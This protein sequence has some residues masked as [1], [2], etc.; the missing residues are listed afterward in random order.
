MSMDEIIRTWKADEE[1]IELH[2][3]ASPVGRELDEHE[4][5]EVVGGV[6]DCTVITC[7]SVYSAIGNGPGILI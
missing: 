4:L 6:Y 3:P 7:W 5:Q 2:L 1:E